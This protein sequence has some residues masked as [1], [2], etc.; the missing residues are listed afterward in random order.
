M[1]D[2]FRHASNPLTLSL[3]KG[4]PLSPVGKEGKGR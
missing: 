4:C 1:N 2:H 3:P